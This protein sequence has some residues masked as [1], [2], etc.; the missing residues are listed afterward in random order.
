MGLDRLSWS[1]IYYCNFC[2]VVYFSQRDLGCQGAGRYYWL[3]ELYVGT[4]VEILSW[5]GSA[6]AIPT[7]VTTLCHG[8][9]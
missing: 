9:D 8:V 2:T 4:P 3:N 6:L 7:L 1:G 5:Y